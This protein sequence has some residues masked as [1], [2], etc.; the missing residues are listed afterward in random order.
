METIIILYLICWLIT[1]F[2]PLQRLINNIFLKLPQNILTESLWTI[3]GC[4]K[5][6]SLWLILIITLDPI[7]AITC[8]M[9]S[10]LQTK[11]VK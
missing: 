2:D 8:S 9:L 6:L 4:Q 7:A 10:Q 1:N 5:C 3:L 11:L